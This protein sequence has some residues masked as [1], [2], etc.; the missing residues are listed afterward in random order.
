[1]KSSV[2]LFKKDVS[3]QAILYILNQ[4]GGKCDIHKCMKIL[5]FSDNAH[6][7]EYGR[8]ITGDTYYHMAYGAVPTHIYDILKAVRGDS[9]FSNTEEVQ[10]IKKECFHFVNNI[11]IVS[12]AMPDMDYLSQSDIEI[13]NMHIEQLRHKT[14]SE[15]TEMS[16]GYAW[17]TTADNNPISIRA[18]L[19][20]MGDTDDFIT[21][22]E[23]QLETEEVFCG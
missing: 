21:Y 17:Q 16:H 23:K 12:T 13:L 11:L 6:L 5:Y 4:M 8:T 2:S 9:Y 3:I 18:R 20:E 22:I 1:M 19:T 14:F 15:V 7:S 10:K